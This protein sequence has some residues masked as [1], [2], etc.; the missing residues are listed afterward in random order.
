[1]GAELGVDEAAWLLDEGDEHMR[2][3]ELCGSVVGRQTL[4]SLRFV[5][6]ESVHI[7]STATLA[8][9][10]ETRIPELKFKEKRIVGLPQ[11]CDP[12]KTKLDGPYIT[13]TWYEMNSY[14]SLG[15]E[16]AGP[17]HR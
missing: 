14:R 15:S 10:I 13:T 16:Y 9:Q 8:I 12:Y 11:F 4:L 5:P 6:G 1:M 3:L 17:S 7:L 2:L